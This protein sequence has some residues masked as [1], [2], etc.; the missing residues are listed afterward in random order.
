MQ[1]VMQSV[2]WPAVAGSVVWSLIS[3]AVKE[4]WLEREVFI[5][6]LVLAALAFYLSAE[7]LSTEQVPAAEA[8]RFWRGD[9]PLSMAIAVFAIM[10]EAKQA[11]AAYALA[12][13][14]CVGVLGHITGVWSRNWR[15][16][17]G[18]RIA[19]IFVHLAG[20]VIVGPTICRGPLEFT[21]ALPAA[22]I[23]VIVGW[24]VV[25]RAGIK[26]S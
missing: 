16:W 12:A 20:L 19:M 26:R 9:F 8:T 4:D 21:A 23:A 6:L 3:V 13:V 7:W 1:K 17:T 11:R 5:R 15:D 18:K 10:T 25:Q 22:V 14:F 2:L 24:L